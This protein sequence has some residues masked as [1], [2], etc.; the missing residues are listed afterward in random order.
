MGIEGFSHDSLNYFR[1]QLLVCMYEC[2]SVFFTIFYFFSPLL[3]DSLFD[4]CLRLLLDYGV[5]G[6]YLSKRISYT[7]FYFEY[8]VFILRHSW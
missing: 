4:C 8:L 3:F 7:V 5:N 6:V 2:E 1:F